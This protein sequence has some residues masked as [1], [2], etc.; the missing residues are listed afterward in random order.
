[1]M[2]ITV[3][4]EPQRESTTPKRICP[5]NNSVLL[6][7]FTEII[8]NSSDQNT[9]SATASE[10]EKYSLI[11]YMTG[12]PYNWWGQQHKEFPTLS[13]LAKCF[14]STPALLNSYSQQPEIYM[15]KREIGYTSPF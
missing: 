3:E 7:V 13:I 9:H 8:A 1:M 14:L 4:V 6:H 15:M 11:D 5:L 2:K 12:D 10:L